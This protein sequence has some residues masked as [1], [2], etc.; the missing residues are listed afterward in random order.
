M[1]LVIDQGNTQVKLAFFESDALLRNYTFP[2]LELALLPGLL[3][4]YRP[5]RAIISSVKNR[6]DALLA[7]LNQHIGRVVELTAETPVPI[8]SLYRTPQTL[9]KDRL[10]AVVGARR[11]QPGRNILVIDAGTAIT[12]DYIDSDGVYH[13]GNI[14]PGMTT[15]FRA[16][17]Y[18]TDKL[19]L[20]SEEGDTPELGYDTLTAIRSGVV[21]GVVREM[22]SYIQEYRKKA[23]VFAFLTGGHSFY[24]DSKLKSSIFADE[25]LVLKGLNEILNYQ[26]D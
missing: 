15:R 4:R 19:P 6:D 24:F 23:K 2:K 21:A 17:N 20:V 7:L 3:G 16:L 22:D 18:Y 12:Y 26:Y 9:G 10:A 11:Q 25:N 13:G 8:R 14:S 5:D 1:N